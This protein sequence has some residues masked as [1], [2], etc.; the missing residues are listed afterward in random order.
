MSL[1]SAG[2]FNPTYSIQRDEFADVV[3]KM[4]N[5]VRELYEVEAYSISPIYY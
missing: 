1:N 5:K 2:K 3:V 4:D